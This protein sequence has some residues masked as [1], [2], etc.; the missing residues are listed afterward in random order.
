MK[1]KTR[2]EMGH[3]V[4]EAAVV[5]TKPMAAEVARSKTPR[6]EMEV[7]TKMEVMG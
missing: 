6:V 4:E 2:M 7:G 1:R 5:M 3:V